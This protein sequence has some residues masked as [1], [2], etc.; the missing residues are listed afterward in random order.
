MGSYIYEFD[1]WGSVF[2][3]PKFIRSKHFTRIDADNCIWHDEVS[4]ENTQIL[5]ILPT[6]NRFNGKSKIPFIFDRILEGTA[7]FGSNH[8][9]LGIKIT[10]SKSPSPWDSVVKDKILANDFPNIVFFLIAPHCPV[11]FPLFSTFFVKGNSCHPGSMY[12]IRNKQTVINLPLHALWTSHIATYFDSH[13][14]IESCKS[15]LAF[16]T[17]SGLID[18]NGHPLSQIMEFSGWSPS[19]NLIP[20]SIPFNSE[21]SRRSEWI[22]KFYFFRWRRHL[23]LAFSSLH[24]FLELL[25]DLIHGIIDIL[26]PSRPRIITYPHSSGKRMKYSF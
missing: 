17:V 3:K 5:L 12:K 13:I 14:V 21:Q 2:P 19:S 24:V 6:S 22:Q 9:Y 16:P 15:T 4:R 23:N 7:L 20:K 11:T 25:P 26:S 10:E 18:W 8:C 1:S